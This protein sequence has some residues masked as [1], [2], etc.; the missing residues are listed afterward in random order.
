MYLAYELR[1]KVPNEK[2]ENGGY[3]LTGNYVA[4]K[5]IEWGK[6]R[7]LSNRLIEDPLKG[8]TVSRRFRN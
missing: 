8:E 6:V 3:E 5:K 2:G 7:S 1:V 4:I